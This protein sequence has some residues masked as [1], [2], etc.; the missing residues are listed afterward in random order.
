M[1]WIRL[2][3]LGAMGGLFGRQ[4][5]TLSVLAH[6]GRSRK[7]EQNLAGYV[8]MKMNLCCEL[9]SVYPADLVSMYTKLP[10]ILVELVSWLPSALFCFSDDNPHPQRDFGDHLLLGL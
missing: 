3:A 7:P 5:P 9:L 8:R 4:S 1:L 6:N 2:Q 10:I